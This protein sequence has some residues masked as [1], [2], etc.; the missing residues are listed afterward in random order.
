MNPTTGDP[1]QLKTHEIRRLQ[2]IQA[3]FHAGSRALN[4]PIKI[5]NVAVT[6]FDKFRV[7]EFV[8]SAQIIPWK[9]SG[10]SGKAVEEVRLEEWDRRIKPNKAEFKEFQDEKFYTKWAQD[11]ITVLKSQ[12]L[13]HTI[14]DEFTPTHLELDERQ[15]QW[16]YNLM[17]P[18]SKRLP[19][20]ELF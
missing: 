4:Q 19:S 10:T 17:T 11:F 1:A 6:D 8:P 13:G 14:N 18:K 9:L 5:A 20:N 16:T 15:C 3:F 7:S 2:A 12:G